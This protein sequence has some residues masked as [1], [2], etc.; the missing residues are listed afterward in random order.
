MPPVT[1]PAPLPLAPRSRRRVFASPEQFQGNLVSLSP[2]ETHHLIR[3]LRLVEGD[4][5]EVVDGC[6]R[7]VTALISRVT[8]QG[9]RLQLGD[10]LPAHGE[11]PLHLTV[12]LALVRADAFDLL[13]RQLTE[14]GVQQLIPFYAQRSLARPETWQPQ[15]LARWQRLAQDAL[16]SSE[17]AYLPRISPPVA[18]PEVLEGGEEVK[19]LCW[20]DL[21]H[22]EGR[23][24]LTPDLQ[25]RSVRL[26]IGPEGGFTQE[27]VA[28]AQAVGFLPM[29]LGPRRLRVETA[30][31]V[32]VSLVQYLWGDMRP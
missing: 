29:A 27:E 26:L 1:M 23:S 5:V 12:G 25:P 7:I 15:K 8:A 19:I 6:G 3:V 14:M 11:S 21:R 9:V 4:E 32:A 28:A 17:R 18:F 2:A 10:E 20:E 30:A 16:K 13:V 31:V 22:G 24:S